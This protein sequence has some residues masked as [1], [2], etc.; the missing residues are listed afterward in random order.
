MNLSHQFLTQFKLYLQ[1]IIWMGVAAIFISSQAQADGVILIKSH[2]T[3]SPNFWRAFTFSKN[4]ASPFNYTITLLNGQQ[5]NFF[6]SEVGAIIEEP[7]WN[8]LIITSDADW[9]KLEQQKSKL[10]DSQPV[11]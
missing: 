3:Q 5:Q 2:P 8:E 7:K 9:S 1:S 4:E 11:L 10:L 6:K